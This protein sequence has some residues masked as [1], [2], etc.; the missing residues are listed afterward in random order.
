LEAS[1]QNS[2]RRANYA[3][4]KRTN[5]LDS[6]KNEDGSVSEVAG[7]VLGCPSSVRGMNKVSFLHLHTQSASDPVATWGHIS[8]V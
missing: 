8:R 1:S 3:P 4:H 6:G 5:L 7:H 2:A